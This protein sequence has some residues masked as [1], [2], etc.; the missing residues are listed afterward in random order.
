MV[1]DNLDDMVINN[2][3]IPSS[4][5]IYAKFWFYSKHKIDSESALS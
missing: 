4:D 5:Y 3:A 1:D 2:T